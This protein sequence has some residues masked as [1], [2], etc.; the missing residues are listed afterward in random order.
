[1]PGGFVHVAVGL[2]VGAGLR[3][4]S[5]VRSFVSASGKLPSW[6]VTWLVFCPGGTGVPIPSVAEVGR[7]V[8]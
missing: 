7:G 4:G 6:L 5:R 2:T 1:M 3:A 8:L